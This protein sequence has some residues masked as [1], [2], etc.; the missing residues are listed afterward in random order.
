M[1]ILIS[2]SYFISYDPK[3][4]N[5][6]KPFP[7]L[8]PLHLSTLIKQELNLEVEFFD[9]M[10]DKDWKILA[11]KINSFEPDIFILYDDDFNYL[12]KMCLENMRDA[13]FSTIHNVNKSGLFIA[14]GSDASDQSVKYL[15]AG[16]DFIVNQNAEQ[17]ILDIL[18]LI[19]KNK[20]EQ[21]KNLNSVS[22][23]KN[24][25][26]VTNQKA[27]TNFPIENMPLPDWQ[28]IDLNPYKEE[29]IKHHKYFAIN[30]STS[31]GCPFRCNWC[32]KPLYGRTYKVM[33]P[34][35]V[36]EHFNFLKNTIHVDYIWITDDIFALKPG[37]IREFADEINK[38][39]SKIPYKIQSRADLITE[40]YVNGLSESGCDEVWLGVESGSQKI[41][42][43]MDKDLQVHQ[44]FDATRLLKK[45]KIKVA[46]FLQY[47]YPGE[48]YDDI[49]QTLSLIKNGKP[50]HIGISVS[51]PLKN[52]P[53]YNQV[54]NEMKEKQNW[55][56]SGDLALMYHGKY[57]PDFYRKLHTFTHH[58]FG[59]YS[60]FRKQSLVKRIRRL[61]AQYKH[62]PGMLGSRIAMQKYL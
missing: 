1:K 45:Y 41:L 31:H 53:F 29:W 30:V 54:V 5:N 35:K 42:D 46:Y 27:T 23:F 57:E 37:W 17:I 4:A 26:L 6:H 16:F 8:A 22:Y 12:T 3:E 9:V 15:K 32:A 43:A 62:L 36:A 49:K 61:A 13:I 18:T 55:K 28:N 20:P 38:I 58:Y 40:E 48:E 47:G 51:Y 19:I 50:D 33:T 59:F 7:P 11:N 10:F 60:I 24:E 56:D 21:I 44:T 14:H 39:N 52:T 25:T 2:H 34:Q